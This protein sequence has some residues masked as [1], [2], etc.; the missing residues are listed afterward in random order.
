MYVITARLAA[1]ALMA[2]S[3]F[4]R[5][6]WGVSLAIKATI[7]ARQRPPSCGYPQQ[8]SPRRCCCSNSGSGI[9]SSSPTRKLRYT[10]AVAA[11]ASDREANAVLLGTDTLETAGRSENS[12][13]EERAGAGD[14]SSSSSDSREVL[15]RDAWT[16]RAEAHRAR[17][18]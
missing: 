15:S 6:P 14:R 2:A 10:T 12:G 5:A 16:A 1:N 11:T 13:V 4:L 18:V 9:V 7:S 8:P 17:C 3:A